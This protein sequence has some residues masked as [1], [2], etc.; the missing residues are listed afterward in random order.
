M[1]G[2]FMK[3]HF[4]FLFL[5]GA[6]CFCGTLR[7]GETILLQDP[8]TAQKE[9]RTEKGISF[10]PEGLRVVVTNESEQS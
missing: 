7:S 2:G 6:F 8:L 3:K 10:G 5:L 4:S 1:I 9:W